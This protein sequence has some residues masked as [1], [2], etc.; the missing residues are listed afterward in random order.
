MNALVLPSSEIVM[1]SQVNCLPL[2]TAVAWI[3]TDAAAV[4]NIDILRGCWILGTGTLVTLVQAG[5]TAKAR[6]GLCVEQWSRDH[7]L[8]IAATGAATHTEGRTAR[9][10]RHL[11]ALGCICGVINHRFGGQSY[12]L[13]TAIA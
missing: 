13:R 3:G 11:L 12:C 8:Q 5:F 10:G 1:Q 6:F 9:L 7:T 4:D 2:L